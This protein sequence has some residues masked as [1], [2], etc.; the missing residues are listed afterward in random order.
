MPL[1]GQSLLSAESVQTDDTLAIF[2]LA[3]RYKQEFAR[4][5]QFSVKPVMSRGPLCVAMLFFEPSTRT[6]MSFEFAAYRLGLNVVTLENLES[7]SLVK[8]E[9]TVD[10]VRNVSAMNPDLICIRYGM[11]EDLDSALTKLKVPVINCGSGIYEHPTQALLDAFTILEN[12]GR[13]QAERVLIVGDLRHSRVA[14][15]NLTILR[16]SG[17]EVAYCAPDTNL[18][19]NPRW[20]DVQRFESLGEGLRWAS[21]CMC[22]RN[23]TERHH[24]QKSSLTPE[25]YSLDSEALAHFPQDGIIL[26]PGP[27]NIGAEIKV[28]ALNDKR[29]RI[30]NQVENGVFV[31]AAILATIL[32]VEGNSL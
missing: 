4:S 24:D 16:Q 11:D 9:T 31:R 7:S 26:H 5:R 10:T 22:L 14:N 3:Q 19:Q 18:P 25:V 1:F 32:G 28:E 15:S 12:R 23:Q 21:V 20:N 29:V 27:V 13:I 8:G 17:A 2:H 6:R 30:L